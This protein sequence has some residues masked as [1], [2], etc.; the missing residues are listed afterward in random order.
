MVAI[1]VV[2]VLA[3]A[4]VVLRQPAG[5]FVVSVV[6]GMIGRSLHGRI[7][8]ER[9]TGDI[10]TH[11]RFEGVAVV[12]GSDSV[13]AD[14][15]A[16]SY[17]PFGFL[18]G[19]IPLSEVEIHGPSVFLSTRRKPEPAAA[20]TAKARVTY[21]R[22]NLRR[23]LV[24]DGAVFL[25]GKPRAE[26]LYLELAV[27]AVPAELTARL[28]GARANLVQ[29]KI[30]VKDV[31]A[32]CRLT[33]DS[34]LLSG[35]SV[36][37]SGSRLRGD[38]ALAMD[39]SGA[40][41]ELENLSVDLPEFSDLQGHVQAQGSARVLAGKRGGDV[42][43]LAGGL[44]LRD[45]RLPTIRGRLQLAEPELRFRASGS[46]AALGEF[47]VDGRLD[48]G[49]LEFEANAQ[50]RNL[51]VQ[52]LEPGLPA[53]LLQA[54]ARLGGKGTDSVSARIGARVQEL[55]MDTLLLA[56]TFQSGGGRQ[57]GEGELQM[58]GLAG[59]LWVNG[60]LQ[61]EDGRWQVPRFSCAMDS[62]DLGLAGLLLDAPVSGRLKGLL[63]GSGSPDSFE[64]KGGLRTSGLDLAGVSL[65]QG[66]AEF[67]M[68]I[69]RGLHGRLLVGADTVR[70]SGLQLEA[71]Q[72]LLQDAE[73]DL[74]IDRTEDQLLAGGAIQLARDGARCRV[75][76]F[77]FA[78]REE[79]LALDKPFDF[80]WAGDSVSAR[81][82]RYEV[83]DGEIEL[84]VW[85]SGGPLPEVRA[86]GTNLDLRKLQRLL[87]LPIEARG[88]WGF[89]VS[90]RDSFRVSTSVENLELPAIDMA[91]KNLAVDLSAGRTGAFLNRFWFVYDTDTTAFSG[92]LSYDLSQGFAFSDVDISADIND[93]G[94]WVLFFLKPTLEFVSGRIYGQ[95]RLR[96]DLTEPDLAGRLRVVTGVLSFPALNMTLERVNAELTASGDR[97]VLEKL[98]AASGGG[99]ATASGFVDLGPQWQVDS[100]RYRI[101]PDGAAISPLPE[102][103]AVVGGDVSIFWAPGL[104]FSIDG[105]VDVEEALLAFGFGQSSAGGGGG[106][107]DSL[108]YDLRIRGQRGIWLRNPLAD[109]E[110]S[111]DLTVRKTMTEE[112]YSGQL[113]SRQGNIYYL[114]HTLRVTRGV[115]RFDNIS[116]IN[117]VLDIAAQMPVSARLRNGGTAPDSIILSL[118]GT[119]EKPEF[120]LTAVPSVWDQSQII[121]Y[122]SLN[123]TP[124]ELL[125]LE[126]RP[127][128]TRY[129]SERLLGYFQTQAAKQVR[130]FVGLDELRFESAFAGGEGYKVTVGKYVGRNL[131][132]TYTQNFTGV[133]QPAFTVEY[134]LNR[135][136]E[137]VGAKS[138]E[139]RYSVRYQ[140]RIRY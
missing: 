72:L 15:L 58:R 92:S 112:T 8:Y 120:A 10:F 83:A 91:L 97:I 115:I 48:I 63:T 139:G 11:P 119:L 103:Y 32:A 80:A 9:V 23:L 34:V 61:V 123:V 74:R 90:G 102:V 28:R 130:K 30:Q 7:S 84:D 96:G 14:E 49:N 86:R 113:A 122:M 29:E 47:S 56:G 95:L 20:D 41:A 88:T 53:V 33:P 107:G 135:G 101:R 4:L 68:A 62:L 64:V 55:G 40:S 140:F 136:S 82:V 133:L 124:D 94:P 24:S 5:R 59:W 35:L 131:Y 54:D 98:S 3:G 69:G 79:T 18:R 93:P 39:G 118:T 128:A 132:L 108:V 114:D 12:V 81:G 110:L 45:I 22:L 134:Y 27:R 65:T 129:L 50:F 26:S 1:A 25:D 111:A 126:N 89:E 137:I 66:L 13:K 99:L 36:S 6:L 85:S 109:I 71:A 38:L 77:Q 116:R 121:T 100:L 37:T 21:P 46:D 60:R 17:D 76:R 73:F 52:R 106:S 51:K 117:P 44:V 2:L 138:E 104:P 78:T 125:G 105:T 67:D 16:F 87:R 43:Y 70:T 19:R 127:N 75:D 31:S 42:E 57:V